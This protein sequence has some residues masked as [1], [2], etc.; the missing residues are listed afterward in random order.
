MEAS[1]A[2]VRDDLTDHLADNPSLKAQ[3]PEA[4]ASAYRRAKREAAAETD[5]PVSIFPPD[6]PW[7]FDRLMDEGFWPGI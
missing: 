3:V 2:N 6:C 4:V 5:L 7:P 1:I